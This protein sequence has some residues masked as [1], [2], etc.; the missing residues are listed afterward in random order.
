MARR[1]H[2]ATL[3]LIGQSLELILKAELLEGGVPEEIL[4][5]QPY[6][7]DLVSMLAQPECAALKAEMAA[8]AVE[9]ARQLEERGMRSAIGPEVSKTD[10]FWQMID[11]LAELHSPQS[12]F[13]LRYPSPGG[14]Y[15]PVPVWL[16]L[17]TEAVAWERLKARSGLEIFREPFPD[18]LCRGRVGRGVGRPGVIRRSGPAAPRTPG[19]PSDPVAR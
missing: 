8:R 4:K 3:V 14:T 6:G 11:R 12:G 18:E 5:R 2:R 16:Y 13:A 7:H 15:A 17:V 1:H 9:C 19:S 10:V